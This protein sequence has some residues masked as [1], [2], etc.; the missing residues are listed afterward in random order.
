VKAL[1]WLLAQAAPPSTPV[2]GVDVDQ[3][4]ASAAQ[5]TTG[6]SQ[7]IY[8]LWS[9]ESCKAR[10]YARELSLNE[11]GSYTGHDLVSPCPRG[12]QCSWTGI[13]TWG[14]T[15]VRVDDTLLL[16]ETLPPDRPG[17]L[18][19]PP[20]LV[21]DGLVL[22]EPDCAWRPGAPTAADVLR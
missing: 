11:D 8:G 13:V 4:A 10:A 21:F 12:A 7:R 1:L 2:G 5:G 15:W 18:P 22:R 14:G 20:E 6:S 19:R 17:I 16:M 3:I 9:S